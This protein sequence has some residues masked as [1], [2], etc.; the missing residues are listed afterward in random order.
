MIS[1]AVTARA[2]HDRWRGWVIGSVSL[3]VMLLLSMAIYR[4]I[5]LA[6]YTNLPEAMIAIMGIPKDADVASLAY[7]A[8]YGTYGG[9]TM[10]ALA[11]AAGSASI[12]GEERGGTIGLLLGNPKS[13]THVLLAKAVAVAVLA[14]LGALILW[15]A[16]V[17]SA[18]MLGVEITGIFVGALSFHIFVNA[19]F[20]GSLAMAI[21]AWT[22][23]GS[24]ASGVTA[25]VMLL[26]FIA[27][28]VLPLV[29]GFENIAKALP[30]YYFDGSRPALNGIHWGHIGVLLIGVSSFT[31]IAVFGL[32]RRDLRNQARGVTLS[33]RLR[34]NPM[35]AKVVDRLAGSI[36]VSRIWAKTASEHQG[37]LIVTSAAM[38]LMMGV[39]MGP[40]YAIF[41]DTAVG[42]FDQLPE[43]LMA[44]FG[45]GNLA[46]P[47]GWYQI[48]TFGMMAPMA[49][50]AVT[51]AIGASSL[52]GEEARGTM[53]LLLANPVRRSRIVIEKT[54][55][56]VLYGFA[57]GFATFAGV[58]VGSLIGG[59][60]MN[61]ANIAAT[62][63]L[64][65]LLGLTFGAFALAVSAALG[66]VRIAVFGTIGI[67]LTFHMLN[68]F[69]PLSDALVGYA[70]WT[71]FYYYL[72][73]DPLMNGMQWDHAATLAGLTI[74]LVALSVVL[75]ERR[76]LRQVG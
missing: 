38:F 72:T 16:G 70:K 41:D 45:G 56:M 33:D 60:G 53:G 54:L 68:A 73:S 10:A 9:L 25:G 1:V 71:P 2:V 12:A 19:L 34:S 51:V 11:L 44:L 24:V 61:T 39:M 13:R 27:V 28:G 75:F 17:L 63:L 43:S 42:M 22:G 23:R 66:R 57:V 15:G 18:A 55:T 76:D 7:G 47:E 3:G 46:T 65:T 62:S 48:E 35:T 20:Y 74:G 8:V 59:L 4:D 69:L 31:V 37:L 67:A 5:D 32:N 29:Q 40:M 6:F 64:V 49:V 14:G 52:A 30:W 21:G 58:A 36:R 26:S 50:M